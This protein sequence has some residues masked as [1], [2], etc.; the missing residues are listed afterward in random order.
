MDWTRLQ[1][2]HTAVSICSK[3]SLEDPTTP[4]VS[5]R[6]FIEP[7]DSPHISS[8]DNHRVRA[9][10]QGY[11]CNGSQVCQ[12]LADGSSGYACVSGCPLG[13]TSTYQVSIGSYVRIP[14][15]AKQKGCLKI[16][17]CAPS[18]RIEQCQPLPC[19]S[20]DSCSLA[21]KKIEHSTWFYLE[22]NVCSCFAGEITCTRKQCRVTGMSE[23]S[24]TSMPCNCPPHHVPVCGRNGATYAS[25]C[26][27]KC[28]GK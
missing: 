9:P 19:I 16:C 28:A 18:G 20:Y 2:G 8:I 25:A 14:V 6:P 10:C 17:R 21:G 4:C 23:R 27:A 7:S 11:P 13:E 1:P 22:C 3:L 26:V 5:I 15:S 12:P 24:Y